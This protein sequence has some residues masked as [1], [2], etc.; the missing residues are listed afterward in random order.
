MDHYDKSREL[1]MS[2]IRTLTHYLIVDRAAE[3]NRKRDLAG[4]KLIGV[5][6]GAM[7]MANMSSLAQYLAQHEQDMNVDRIKYCIPL[8]TTRLEVFKLFKELLEVGKG[9]CGSL[10]KTANVGVSQ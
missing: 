9:W 10:S 3:P 5:L 7:K 2:I 8:R 1:L 4:C 6:E